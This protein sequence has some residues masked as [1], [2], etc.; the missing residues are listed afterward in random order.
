MYVLTREKHVILMC[1]LIIPMNRAFLHSILVHR[2]TVRRYLIMFSSV[3][4]FLFS[5]T[6]ESRRVILIQ[7]LTY[8]V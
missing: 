7:D 4:L 3:P 5:K 1:G 6:V 2:L 8:E